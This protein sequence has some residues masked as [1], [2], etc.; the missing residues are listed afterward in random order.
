M[1]HLRNIAVRQAILRRLAELAPQSPARWGRMNANQMICHLADS[2]RAVMGEK[3]VSPAT[4]MLQ[5][6]I[7]KWIALYVPVRWPKCVP[8][9]PE[10]EQGVGGTPPAGFARDRADLERVIQL[11]ADPNHQFQ[12]HHHPIFGDMSETE[13]MRWVFLH[14]DH[15]LRQFGL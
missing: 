7:V 13:W 3:P 2:Y 5:R 4:G 8:T 12:W 14:V 1:T 6:T 11:F 10:M 9:R 15:H